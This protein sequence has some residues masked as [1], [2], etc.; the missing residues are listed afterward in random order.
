MKEDIEMNKNLISGV[1]TALIVIVNIIVFL[2]L[3]VVNYCKNAERD[4]P[5]MFAVHIVA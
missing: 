1:V 5:E 4:G 3:I 2:K